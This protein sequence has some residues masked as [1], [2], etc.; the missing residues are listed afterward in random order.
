MKT[1][2]KTFSPAWKHST[3]PRKQRVYLYTAPLHH[4]Q[5][6]LHVHLAPALRQKYGKRNLQVRKGDKVRV[7]RGQFAKREAT[8]ERVDL[9][10][11]KIFAEGITIVKKDGTKIPCPLRAPQLMLV[12]LVLEDQRRKKKLESKEQ[13]TPKKKT[14][15]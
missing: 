7:L 8:V 12:S 4:K 5:K 11:G 15:P 1:E 3:Q 10:H 14:K 6:L 9:L 13:K 2:K